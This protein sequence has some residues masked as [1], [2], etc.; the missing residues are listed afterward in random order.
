MTLY[1]SLSTLDTP[2]NASLWSATSL[3]SGVST[4]SGSGG[5]ATGECTEMIAGLMGVPLGCDLPHGHAGKHH[6]S[7][8]ATWWAGWQ[9]RRWIGRV[10]IALGE[11]LS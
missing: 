1:D 10:L 6:D 7:T 3:E 8:G 4:A 9:R 2:A 11:R 5:S